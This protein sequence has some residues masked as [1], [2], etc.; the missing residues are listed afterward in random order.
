ML[1]DDRTLAVVTL[2]EC[3]AVL[4]EPQPSGQSTFAVLDRFIRTSS[5]LIYR[6][7]KAQGTAL[8]LPP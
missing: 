8:L 1:E 4:R 3:D 7:S 5:P 6:R 2:I